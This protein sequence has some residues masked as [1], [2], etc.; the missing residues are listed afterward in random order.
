M[1]D[2]NL[3]PDLDLKVKDVMEGLDEYELERQANIK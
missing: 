3:A 2:A 1:A